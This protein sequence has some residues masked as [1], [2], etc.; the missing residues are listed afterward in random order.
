MEPFTRERPVIRRPARA[1]LLA[2]TAVALPLGAQGQAS[3]GP[4]PPVTTQLHQVA[5]ARQMGPVA[6]RDPLGVISPDG[7]RIAY[8][9]ADRIV[10]APVRAAGPVVRLG[11]GLTTLRQLVWH[12]DG[13]RIAALERSF[14][15]AR[16]EWFV[17]DV[18]TGTRTALWPGGAPDVGAVIELAWSSDGRLAVVATGE[19]VM[20]IHEIDDQGRPVAVLAEGPGLSSPAWHPD[21]R[22]ACLD[23]DGARVR[24]LRLPCGTADGHPLSG[25]E[26]YG[27]LAFSADGLSIYLARPDSTGFLDLWAHPLDGGDALPIAAFARD[28][29]APSVSG[30]GRV[31]F[32]VQDYR[33]NVAVAPV[34]EDGSDQPRLLTTFQSETPTW[35][36]DGTT[37]AFTFGSWRHV[38]DDLLYPDIA[39]H[40]GIV[41]VEGGPRHA[42]GRVVRSSTSEDQGLSWSPDGRW[43][44]FHSHLGSDDIFVMPSDGSREAWMISRDGNETGWPRWSPDGRWVSFTTYRRDDEGARQAFIY[45]VGVDPATG[46]VTTPQARLDWGDFPYDAIHAEWAGSG[47]ELVF[48]AAEGPGRK[49]LYRVPRAGG[50]PEKFH[51]FDSDQVHS[52]IGASPDG[53]EVAYVAPDAAGFF[54]IW[55]VA[56]AGGTPSPVTRDASHKTQPAWSPDGRRIAFTVWDYTAAFWLIEP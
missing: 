50:R 33:V 28:A 26:A 24:R 31:L 4:T 29:Y 53:S 36:P 18:R 9:E 46:K 23:A 10:V 21:G 54:Q 20:R 12:P 44:A 51:Q 16:S 3:L 48:E 38:T 49:G 47:E 27:P 5:T 43:M 25:T 45:L 11:S 41:E 39:Q 22:L 13:N 37:V 42:P 15:R 30:T 32:K 56:T 7:E 52:G 14:D 35:S 19:G 17:H 6:Y 55:R 40:L 8:T 34:A 1:A 2:A